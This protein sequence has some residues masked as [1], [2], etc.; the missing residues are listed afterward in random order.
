MSKYSATTSRMWDLSLRHASPSLFRFL[1]EDDEQHKSRTWEDQVAQKYYASLY[2]EYAVCD[3][4]HYK[5]GN[6]RSAICSCGECVSDRLP[7]LPF[8]SAVCIAL[9]YGSGGHL[10]RG[11]DDLRQHAV[12]PSR[13]S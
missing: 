2:R 9:A 5:S 3:L 12:S 4:K 8:P 13:F 11:R 10:R 1:R 7:S 6:V